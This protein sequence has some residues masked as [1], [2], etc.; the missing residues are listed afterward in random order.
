MA[1]ACTCG[2]QGCTRH[3]RA[4]RRQRA[5]AW[6]ADHQRRR[7][8]L[9]RAMKAGQVPAVCGR[10]LQPLDPDGPWDAGHVE[11]VV[12]G[13]GPEVRPEHVR[14]NRRHG[15][16][17]HGELRHERIEAQ[18]RRKIAATE[19]VIS[20]IRPLKELSRES[21]TPAVG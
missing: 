8:E 14:C 13:G 1:Y 15:G 4:V 16:Q 12:L 6:G 7:R 11:A 18:A 2:V 19:A 17:L 20:A 21:S 5:A 10:C 9:Y 3:G